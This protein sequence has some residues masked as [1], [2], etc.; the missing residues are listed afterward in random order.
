MPATCTPD[1]YQA[2]I[3]TD[4]RKVVDD[5]QEVESLR[6]PENTSEVDMHLTGMT[7]SFSAMARMACVLAKE[8]PEQFRKLA[9]IVRYNGTMIWEWYLRFTP[10]EFME[11][12]DKLG[13]AHAEIGQGLYPL[14]EKEQ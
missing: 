14:D 6:T 2:A 9:V 1:I 3:E 4:K 7:A 13:R 10:D 8:N 12:M 11:K 5:L